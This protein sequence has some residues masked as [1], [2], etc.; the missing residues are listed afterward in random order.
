M[1]ASMAPRAVVFAMSN[2]CRRTPAVA[3]AVRDDLI[4]GTG[5][6]DYPNQVNNVL[7][8]PFIFRGAL[9]VPGGR[10]NTE[11][12]VAAGARAARPG[13]AARTAIRGDGLRRPAPLSSAPVYHP[14]PPTRPARG[15]AARGGRAPPSPAAWPA[16]PGRRTTRWPEGE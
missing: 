3:Q 8:F 9:D 4:H 14:K 7:G 2:P 16:C 13:A 11:M 10:I 6:S 12:N 5:R 15:R 1:V